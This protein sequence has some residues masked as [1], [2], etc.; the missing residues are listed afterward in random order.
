MSIRG[1][2]T[3]ISLVF[4]KKGDKKKEFPLDL[5]RDFL[6]I[7]QEAPGFQITE[8]IAQYIIQLYIEHGEILIFLQS[9]DR[10]NIYFT[11][12]ILKYLSVEHSIFSDLI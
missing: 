10:I 12:P 7:N 5:D 6:V 9:L 4:I 11:R 1:L 2:V 3:L 8:S